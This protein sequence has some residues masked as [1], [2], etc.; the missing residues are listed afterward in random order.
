MR[1]YYCSSRDGKGGEKVWSSSTLLNLWTKWQ[2]EG[3]TASWGEISAVKSQKFGLR[4]CHSKKYDV[5]SSYL[6]KKSKCVLKNQRLDIHPHAPCTRH[7]ACNTQKCVSK[8]TAKFN[9]CKKM[10]KNSSA[11]IV[12]TT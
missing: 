7:G 1:K 2:A 5:L 4:A 9:S 12:S 3:Y 8:L 6:K 10:R 11:L